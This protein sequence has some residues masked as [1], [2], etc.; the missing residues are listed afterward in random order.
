L[1]CATLSG[2][3]DERTST[4][5]GWQDGKVSDGVHTYEYSTRISARNPAS[6][7]LEPSL[8]T[9][10][11]WMAETE[12]LCTTMDADKDL[13][14]SVTTRASTASKPITHTQIFEPCLSDFITP[15]SP[16]IRGLLDRGEPVT[17]DSLRTS[18]HEIQRRPP[19]ILHK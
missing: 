1:T 12:Y 17:R 18:H 9:L 16:L 14:L 2:V 15:A 4:K 6:I 8:Q 13:F 19:V 11:L 7:L 5:D 10:R 3:V